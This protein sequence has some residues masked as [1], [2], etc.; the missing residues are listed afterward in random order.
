MAHVVHGDAAI[1]LRI[2]DPN[3]FDSMVTDPPA[4]I[5]FMGK[6]WD[7]S[8]GGRD[9]WIDWLHGVMLEAFLVMKPGAHGLVWALPR[10]SHWTATALEDAGFEVRDIITH[11]F[12]SGF[13]KSLD[14]SKA[15]DKQFGVERE[16]VTR[17]KQRCG[18]FAHSGSGIEQ[19]IFDYSA[20]ITAPATPEAKQ[21]DGWGTALKPAS[22][23]WILVRKPIEESVASNVLEH[24]VGGLNIDEC[25][26]ETDEKLGRNNKARFN[27]TSYIVQRKDL[28]IDN[29]TGKGR[30]PANLVLSHHPDCSKQKCV[31]DC[32]VRMLD[33]QIGGVSRFFYCAKPSKKERGIFNDH[34]TVKSIKLIRYLT[35]LITPPKGTI[36]DPFAG[37]GAIG[38]AA[39]LEG[40]DYVGIEIDEGS[41]E[42]ATERLEKYKKQAESRKH[43]KIIRKVV[44]K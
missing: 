27:G 26:I 24:G 44:G 15:I 28:I 1:V 3:T 32:P 23:Y 40:F 38:C 36:L 9:K 5:H 18:V 6:D 31:A 33:E 43:T 22:E 8:K 7:S 11:L 29:S 39:V 16:V 12:G 37:S 35:R 14:V 10:T 4:G 2:F 41:H 34:P 30:F 21:W 42:L 17:T 25:R 13:P 19:D 20:V